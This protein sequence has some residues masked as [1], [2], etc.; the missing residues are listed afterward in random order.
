MEIF[1]RN[2]ISQREIS[3]SLFQF[4]ISALQELVDSG[5]IDLSSTSV[6]ANL[7][8]YNVF[9]DEVPPQNVEYNFFNLT[10]DFDEGFGFDQ[11]TSGIANWLYRKNNILWSTSGGSYNLTS[12]SASVILTEPQLDFSV[13]IKNNLKDWLTGNNYGIITKLSN[14]Y[15]S[16]TSS[17]FYIKKIFGR[18]TN[19]IMYPIID[20]QWDDKF[21]D[22]INFLYYGSSANIYFYNKSK[23]RYVDIDSTN[24]F[25]G[26]LSLS[27]T[28]VDSS[29]TGSLSSLSSVFISGVSGQRINT[30]I[31]RFRIPT[32]SY[33][34][35]LL[36]Y[37]KA[38]W[39]IT[40]SLSSVV[41]KISKN[42]IINSPLENNASDFATDFIIAVSNFQSEVKFGELLNYNLF[43][44]RK[45]VALET[46]TA[47]STSLNSYIVQN[48]YYKLIDE[49]TGIDVIP[50]ES[51][52]YNDTMN[53][54]KVNTAFLD[55]ERQ[56]RFVFK[57]VEEDN[58]FIFDSPEYIY[59]F[60]LRQ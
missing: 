36:N 3:R 11:S 39:N 2:K 14:Y 46:L 20:V 56:Y 28:G 35:G 51:I 33:T 5:D 38:I 1:G 19:T 6:S 58:I 59:S 26:F 30:G 54:F 15:E 60:Y 57:F 49:R 52:S 21:T 16:L 25:P 8:L 45:S 7:K 48:A 34:A 55:T 12:L 23:G 24:N 47:S 44:R 41:S 13:N 40:S 18:L 43:V 9:S 4:S 37:N 17:D 32:I 22:D 31:Y 29:Q 27:G 10:E 53:F 42:I 50:W